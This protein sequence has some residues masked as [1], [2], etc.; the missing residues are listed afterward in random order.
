MVIT[1]PIAELDSRIRLGKCFVASPSEIIVGVRNLSSFSTAFSVGL[2]YLY[3][4]KSNPFAPS[5]SFGAQAFLVD[6]F[7]YLSRLDFPDRVILN[8][9]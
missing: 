7:S 2:K 3:L 4:A 1:T 6:I 5:P 9:F 8:K